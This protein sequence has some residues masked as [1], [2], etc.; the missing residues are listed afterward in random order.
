MFLF[1][2]MYAQINWSVESFGT[3]AGTF[4]E[5]TGGAAI[6]FNV[7]DIARWKFAFW[8]SK[9]LLIA[10]TLRCR[11]DLRIRPTIHSNL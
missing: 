4:F 2:L 8:T 10:N 1:N 7:E 6:A 11:S 5:C 9:N 3:K